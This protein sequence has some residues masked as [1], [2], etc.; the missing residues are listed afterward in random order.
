MV[1]KKISIDEIRSRFDS[2]LL[3]EHNIERKI[4]SEIMMSCNKYTL[5]YNTFNYNIYIGLYLSE[6]VTM[7]PTM[8]ILS[9]ETSKTKPQMDDLRYLG[10]LRGLDLYV[11]EFLDNYEYIISNN[12]E[13]EKYKRKDKIQKILSNK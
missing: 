8:N 2:R 12:L 6:Y 9:F 11:S 4:I 5:N 3:S 13:Y 1:R 10:K 7:T